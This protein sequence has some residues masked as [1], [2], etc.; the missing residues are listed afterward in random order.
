MGAPYNL[1]NP[2]SRYYC[3]PEIVESFQCQTSK[4][5]KCPHAGC[6]A[7]WNKDEKAFICPCHGSKFDKDGKLLRGPATE[8]LSCQKKIKN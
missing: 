1:P 7:S 2:N 8:G 6:Q 4:S 5:Y 3:Q